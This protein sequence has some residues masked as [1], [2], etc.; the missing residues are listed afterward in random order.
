MH[1]CAHTPHTHGKCGVPFVKG[2][3]YF[4]L[5]KSALVGAQ[6][7][8]LWEYVWKR[9]SSPFKP[10]WGKFN[11]NTPR[12]EQ[13]PKMEIALGVLELLQ[14]KDIP[15]DVSLKKK[16]S[17]GDGI[18]IE[19]KQV[20]PMKLCCSSWICPES[21]MKCSVAGNVECQIC[22]WGVWLIWNTVD[23]CQGFWGL[24]ANFPKKEP[25]KEKGG[26]RTSTVGC[27]KTWIGCVCGCVRA[28]VYM[29]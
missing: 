22:I 8:I 12:M 25:L 21:V 10:E 15:Y 3:I 2:A 14:R 24:I 27:I 11:D 20:F 17:P 1:A 9:G 19:S 28:C 5:I 4:D 16:S 26:W 18:Y 7:L 29:Q 13:T 23:T 6:S